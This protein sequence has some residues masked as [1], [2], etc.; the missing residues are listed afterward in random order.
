MSISHFAAPIESHQFQI[1]QIVDNSTTDFDLF[2]KVKGHTVLYG[3]TGYK[4]ERRETET[5]LRS[6]FTHFLIRL[7]DENRAQMYRRLSALP[8]IEK[9]Q[10][11]KQRIRSIEQ[12]GANFVQCLHEG[13]L[14]PAS[15]EKAKDIVASM[16]NCIGEDLGCVQQ[17]GVLADHDYYTYYHSVRVAAYTLAICMQMGLSSEEQL[18]DLALG[19]ILHDIGKKDVPLTVL[20]KAGALTDEEWNS[21]KSHPT[22]GHESIRNIV[23]SHVPLEIIL[24]HHEKLD[25]SGYPHGLDKRSLMPEVQV[26]TLADVFDALTSTRSYQQ[27]RSRFEALDFMRLKM[28]GS[29]LPPEAFRALVACLALEK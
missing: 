16:V 17:L 4:W 21:M 5:L 19:G 27:K 11:P 13:E 23:L 2:L 20:N 10:A 18:R 8:S 15:I 3:T 14:T 7:E 28:V 1:D 12:I 24:H 25:G 6:G 22:Q 29:K 26:A 9:S